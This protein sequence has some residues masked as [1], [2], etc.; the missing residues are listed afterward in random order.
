MALLGIS[1]VIPSY[2]REAVLV[3]TVR[4]VACQLKD[5]DEIVVVDQSPSHEA[6]TASALH[7]LHRSGKIRWFR[8]S[9]PSICEAMNVGALVA[10]NEILLFLDDDVVPAPDLLEVYR[11]LF[12]REA[13]LAVVNGQILQPWHPG[14]VDAVRDFDLE[15]DFAYSSPATVS[16]LATGNAAIRR[17]VFL[18]AGGMDE[19]F[20][21]GAYRCDADLGFR[22]Q[23]F[24]GRP[25]RFEPRASVRHLQAGG[26]TR[27]HGFKDSWAAIESAIGDYYFGLRWLG[28]R[29]AARH[30]LR[31]L[32]RA[33]FN[34]RTLRRPW[35]VPAVLAREAV[36]LVRA[37][38]RARR[39]PA[40]TVG[41]LDRYPD[42]EV[43]RGGE[44]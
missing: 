30:A 20:A 29:G 42:L 14:P 37:A 34:R 4:A 38:A 17:A 39:G 5:G 22:L 1:V 13:E 6:E 33:P 7:E 36:G 28:C 35:L 11:E 43:W 19:I 9:R 23:A 24:T 40:R 26:G 12:A 27:A 10:E 8:K 18:Q 44:A 16:G 3:E 25:T 41:T 15:F 31:R 32:R 2:R 21:G